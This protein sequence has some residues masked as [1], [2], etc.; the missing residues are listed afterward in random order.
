MEC[1]SM[2]KNA[3]S[4]VLEMMFFVSVDFEDSDTEVQ[5]DHFES[6]IVLFN[7]SHSLSIS[8]CMREPF[9]KMITANFLGGNEKEVTNE[10]VEDV[11]RELANMA[12][13]NYL[14]RTKGNWQLGIPSLGRFEDA[15]G[16]APARLALSCLGEYVGTVILHFPSLR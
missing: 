8:F 15:A 10:E 3:I 11:M 13:G 16:G 7:E 4:E 6:K 1:R 2:M 5:M 9:A 14:R 12:G